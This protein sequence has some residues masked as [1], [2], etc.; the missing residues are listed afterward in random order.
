MAFHACMH[1]FGLHSVLVELKAAPFAAFFATFF[2][3]S[4]ASFLTASSRTVRGGAL[5]AVVV[6]FITVALAGLICHD[7]AAG[8][9]A[10]FRRELQVLTNDFVECHVSFPSHSASKAEYV[11]LETPIKRLH[12][13]ALAVGSIVV[14]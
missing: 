6:E 4:F 11:C 1:C 9:C 7:L 3:S 12:A 8:L 10:S 13:R 14:N 5:T 2:A